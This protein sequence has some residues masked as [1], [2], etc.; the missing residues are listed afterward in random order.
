MKNHLSIEGSIGP[1]ARFWWGAIGGRELGSTRAGEWATVT[2]VIETSPG[3]VLPVI[4]FSQ[5]SAVSRMTSVAY[6]SGL[7]SY[8]M[9]SSIHDLLLVLALS[10]KGKLVLR[11][12]IW[13]FVDAEPLVGSPQE[14]RQVSLN[15]L[16][17]VELGCKRVVDVD[18]DDFPVGLALIEKSH[19]TE[20]LDLL[21]LAG[22]SNQLADLADVQW[23]VVSLRLG[24]GMNCVGVFPCLGRVS[25]HITSTVNIKVYLRE[26]TVV[27]QVTLVGETISNVSEFALLNIL[28]NRVEFLLLGN[29]QLQTLAKSNSLQVHFQL[30][31]QMSPFLTKFCYQSL[32]YL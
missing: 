19:D 7:V 28:L 32:T 1:G 22:V 29:L 11:L 20:D 17:V 23:V 25:K 30:M 4:S 31:I 8:S 2:L 9:V 14:T 18:N 26:G 15:I 12:A 21:D 6:L 10:G 27:P 16:N 3:W 5:A 13:D 24:L